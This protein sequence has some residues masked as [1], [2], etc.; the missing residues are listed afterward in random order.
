MILY[1]KGSQRLFPETVPSELYK[2][3][4]P[5]FSLGAAEVI[6]SASLHRGIVQ[7]TLR[8]ILASQSGKC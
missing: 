3:L 4:H 5:N 8:K 2:L 6:L 1:L 7:E